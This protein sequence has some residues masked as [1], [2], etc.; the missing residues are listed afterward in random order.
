MLLHHLHLLRIFRNTP[1]LLRQFGTFRLFVG[2]QLLGSR[3]RSIL[4]VQ[5]LSRLEKTVIEYLSC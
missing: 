4:D 3:N 5:V 2:L 1:L